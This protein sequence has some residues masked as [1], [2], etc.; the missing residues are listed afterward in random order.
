MI[1]WAG[2]TGRATEYQALLGPNHWSP[3]FIQN[4][5]DWGL[6]DKEPW[7]SRPQ[8]NLLLKKQVLAREKITKPTTKEELKSRQSTNSEESEGLIFGLVA[9]NAN[10]QGPP[11]PNSEPRE[12]HA[13]DASIMSLTKMK[14]V[15][16]ASF[17]AIFPH[18]GSHPVPSSHSRSSSSDHKTIAKRCC[19]CHR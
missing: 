7:W 1:R 10:Y 6:Q 18:P 15:T 11:T 9:S 17:K 8:K 13:S 12:R 14:P 16:I 3:V 4:L 2:V 19:S 5:V